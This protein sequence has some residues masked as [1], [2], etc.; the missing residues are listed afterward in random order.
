MEGVPFVLLQ[1]VGV[2]MMVSGKYC[3]RGEIGKV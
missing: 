2:I 3:F 1:R